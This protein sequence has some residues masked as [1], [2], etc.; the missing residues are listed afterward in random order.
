MRSPPSSVRSSRPSA[1]AA[2]RRSARSAIAARTV[3]ARMWCP[4][5]AATAIA[6]SVSTACAHLWLAR[7]IERQLPGPHF[8]LTFTVP[9]ALRGFLSC[10]QRLGYGALFEASS[11]SIKT[12]VRDSRFVGGDEAGFFG[13]ARTPG[14]ASCSI[15][16]I[17]TTWCRA[18][19]FPQ[20]TAPGMPQAPGSSCPCTRSRKS[21]AAQ[22]PGPH[23]AHRAA[24]RDPG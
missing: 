1:H 7:Q 22:V 12:L 5:L 21:S 9:A 3:A 6:R 8:M 19:R 13:V 4:P 17:F 2:P 16:P 20:T 24:R 15:T 18:G 11:Q 14:G 23:P 10:H